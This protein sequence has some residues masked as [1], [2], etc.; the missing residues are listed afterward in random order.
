MII[1][2]NPADDDSIGLDRRRSTIKR[3][4]AASRIRFTH[5]STCYP[6]ILNRNVLGVDSYLPTYQPTK[7]SNATML[8]SILLFVAAAATLCSASPVTDGERQARD[9]MLAT[10]GT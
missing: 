4:P 2:E 8:K 9:A 3:K 6:L 7:Y 5:K 10:N 1:F